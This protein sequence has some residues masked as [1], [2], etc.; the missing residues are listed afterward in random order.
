MAGLPR[1]LA[2]AKARGLD[3]Y[4]V[5]QFAFD[6]A[7]I[8]SLARRL[9]EAGIDAPYRVGIAG[10]A[11]RTTLIKYALMCGVGPSLRALREFAQA[12]MQRLQTGAG[13]GGDVQGVLRLRRVG[14]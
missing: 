5:G 11:K 9:R 6:A 3:A 12:C 2:A 7:P 14:V 1:K 4:L 8:V 13:T 10:P